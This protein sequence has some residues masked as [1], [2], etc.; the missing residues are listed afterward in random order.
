VLPFL[1]DLEEF[2]RRNPLRFLNFASS[3]LDRLVGIN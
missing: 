2:V 1:F 3:E